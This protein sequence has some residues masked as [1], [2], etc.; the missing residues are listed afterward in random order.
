M[1]DEKTDP[2][3]KEQHAEPAPE[4]TIALDATQKNTLMAILA[5]IGPLILVSYLLAE[6]EPFVKFHIK[7]GLLLVIAEVAVWMLS[8]MLWPLF[9]LIQ[10]A[11]IF[12]FVLAVVG[13]IRAAQ[14]EQ[15]ELPFVG[16][17]AE[18]FKF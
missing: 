6:K 4:K 8:M 12:L 9:P 11:N 10:I 13:I 2:T 14:G 16:H 15:K 17:L 3:A 7:Q 5:Y 1:T 18:N